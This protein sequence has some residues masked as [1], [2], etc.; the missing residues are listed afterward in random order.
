[1]SDNFINHN[2][3]TIFDI[4]GNT[5][6]RSSQPVPIIDNDLCNTYDTKD[7]EIELQYQSIYETAMLSYESQI[8]NI[9]KGS[10]DNTSPRVYEVANEY[11]KTAL[12]CV[13]AKADLKKSKDKMFNVKSV[14]QDN[15]S[16]TNNNIIMDRNELL[17]QLINMSE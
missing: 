17:K 13:K 2:F 7:C 11:L 15:R 12:D 1:M 6:L 14:N 5:T 8:I 4:E 9:E 10:M 3:E 16:I